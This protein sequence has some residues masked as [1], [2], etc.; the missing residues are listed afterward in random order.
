M[1][2][3][4]PA[5]VPNP[6]ADYAAADERIR[7]CFRGSTRPFAL[8]V[9]ATSVRTTARLA[10]LL[11]CS[12][13]FHGF[14]ATVTLLPNPADPAAVALLRWQTAFTVNAVHYFELSEPVSAFKILKRFA[15]CHPELFPV[16]RAACG[17]PA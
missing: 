14:S 7:R 16:A 4:R 2:Y 13:E 3:S 12:I 11:R 15:L 8:A 1:P 6:P 10:A 5:P 17:C 9:S